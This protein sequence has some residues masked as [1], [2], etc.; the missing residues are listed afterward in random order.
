[1]G[2][3][4]GHLVR[5]RAVAHTLGIE[6]ETTVVSASEHV[7]DA[8]VLGPLRGCRAP[9]TLDRNCAAWRAWLGATL[10]E[11]RPAAL[12]VDTFPAGILGELAEMEFPASLQVHHVARLVRAE[13]LSDLFGP[14]GPRFD[15]AYVVEELPPEHWARLAERSRK[16]RCRVLADP[17]WRKEEERQARVIA[18]RHP[19]FWQVVHSGPGEE[20]AE[21]LR[22]ADDLRRQEHA[23]VDLV[24][25][26]TA[27]IPPPLPARTYCW[28]LHPAMTLFPAARRIVSAAGFNVM[29]Q[30]APWREK[31]V[32]LPFPRRWDDQFLRAARRQ[33]GGAAGAPAA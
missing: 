16:V 10:A 9:P 17:P 25:T 14:A 22:F 32:V 26:T 3:G 8:R 12:I 30:A 27:T 13:V 24:V 21:L 29:R 11:F 7:A 19:G 4:L 18:A 2:G 28:D 1:M 23:E 31:H 15:E 5:A 6:V 33:G 20:V